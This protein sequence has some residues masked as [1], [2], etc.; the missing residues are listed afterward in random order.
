M[1]WSDGTGNG[2]KILELRETP[3]PFADAITWFARGLGAAR[4]GHTTAANE[5]AA[6]LKQ[7][8]VRLLIAKETYWARQVEIQALA[9]AAWSALTTGAKEEALR[10]MESAAQM[11]DGTKKGVVTPGPLS[12]ARELLGEMF[13]ETE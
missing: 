9:V 12:P 8:Q 5:A 4:R 1:R 2:R 10:Q 13:L 6:A 11:E 7:I 3:F